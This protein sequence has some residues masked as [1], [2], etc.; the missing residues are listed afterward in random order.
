MHCSNCSIS[1]IR[2][3]LRIVDNQA[4]QHAAWIKWTLPQLFLSVD[5]PFWKSSYIGYL[6]VW[7]VEPLSPSFH[8][9]NNTGRLMIC[10][11]WKLLLL[12]CS[13]PQPPGELSRGAMDD[14]IIN[15]RTLQFHYCNPILHAANFLTAYSSL[16]KLSYII[17]TVYCAPVPLQRCFI[18][19]HLSTGRF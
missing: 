7:L 9:F 1:L 12:Y 15:L 4:F 19:N 5:Y 16:Q 14:Q 3:L 13:R 17:K 10:I 18:P 2:D 11:Y 8:R 6:H